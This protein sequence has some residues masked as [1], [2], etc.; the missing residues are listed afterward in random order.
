MKILVTGGAGFIGSNLVD[1]LVENNEV[2]VFDNLQK[3]KL[4]YVN[5]KAKFIKADVRN[6][7]ELNKVIHDEKIEFVY[8]LSAYA[9]I[10]NN[11]KDDTRMII[12]ENFLCTHNV[13]EAMRANNV[14]KL[15]FLSTSALYGDNSIENP[16]NDPLI[17]ISV[18]SATKVASEKLIMSYCYSFGMQ[19]W[20]FRPPNVVGPRGT[21][22]VIN[23]FIKKLCKNNKELEILGNG[24]QRKSYLYIDDCIDAM[25]FCIEHAKEPVNIFNIAT[26]DLIDVTK[27]AELVADE[28]GLK[29]VKFNY[30]GGESNWIGDVKTIWLSIDKIKKLGWKPKYNSQEAVRLAVKWAKNNLKYLEI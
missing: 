25:L 11:V 4:N 7:D 21:H 9:D 5:K 24:K 16:E 23:D 18:Y 10:R 17:T 28:L 26:G 6:F 2:V 14:K 27:I 12:D 13:L 20:I 1:K 8:H 22:G 19:S 29:N 30:T 3:G 15:C